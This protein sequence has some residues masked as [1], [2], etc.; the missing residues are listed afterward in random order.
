MVYFPSLASDR[1]PVF[2]NISTS[3]SNCFHNFLLANHN[4]IIKL[5]LSDT[6]LPSLLFFRKK[7]ELSLFCIMPESSNKVILLFY[8]SD[9]TDH[10]WTNLM[11]ERH[12]STRALR[13][14]DIISELYLVS[15]RVRQ[16]F[17]HSPRSWYCLSISIT[18][19]STNTE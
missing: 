3:F 13:E 16:T 17:S 8:T 18:R 4:Q 1:P 9:V 6:F 12:F 2:C 5:R 14:L 10:L 7:D 19:V 15:R 11:T